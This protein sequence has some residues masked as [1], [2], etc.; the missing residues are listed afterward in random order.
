[1]SRLHHSSL[2]EKEV[3]MLNQPESRLVVMAGRSKSQQHTQINRST[4]DLYINEVL[5]SGFAG[6]IELLFRFILTIL[7]MA[8]DFGIWSLKTMWSVLCGICRVV[9]AIYI[10]TRTF[11]GWLFMKNPPTMAQERIKRTY[12]V[13][14]GLMCAFILTGAFGQYQHATTIRDNAVSDAHAYQTALNEAR[15]LITLGQEVQNGKRTV[16]VL[17]EEGPMGMLIASEST[18]LG[19]T[20]QIP[21][22]ESYFSAVK[23]IESSGRYFAAHNTSLAYG[24][25]AFKPASKVDTARYGVGYTDR[26]WGFTPTWLSALARSDG[27]RVQ[28]REDQ[29]KLLV[30]FHAIMRTGSDEHLR[31]SLCNGSLAS[32]KTLYGRF[33][34]TNPD[35]KT[36]RLIDREFGYKWPQSRDIQRVV[37]AQRAPHD[38]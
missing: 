26:M 35:T 36:L 18:R 15:P 8:W 11:A 1:M 34:H 28:L 37:R 17:Q 32:A 7:V 23:T 29:M 21:F 5:A 33:H 4:T 14:V 16:S 10:F 31:G 38:S 6:I 22:I 25:Y 9:Q 12:C 3:Q 19:C 24:F 27:T 20:V 13:V 30:M 2:H